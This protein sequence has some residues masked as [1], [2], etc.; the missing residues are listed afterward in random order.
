MLIL[1]FLNPDVADIP[2]RFLALLSFP[3]PAR[4]HHRPA[5]S[6]SS[7]SP[8]FVQSDGSIPEAGDP[9]RAEELLFFAF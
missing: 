3:E 4:F 5:P 8:P 1:F 6:L 9:K 7:I 2:V